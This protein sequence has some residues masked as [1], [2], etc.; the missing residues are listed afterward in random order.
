MCPMQSIRSGI[1]K[2]HRQILQKCL[3]SCVEMPLK[4]AKC[5]LSLFSPVSLM[6]NIFTFLGKEC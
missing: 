6:A 3:I 4:N 5:H 2:T 1:S